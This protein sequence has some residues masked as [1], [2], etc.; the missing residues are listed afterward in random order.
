MVGGD[1]R[2]KRWDEWIKELEKEAEEKTK[3]VMR[4]AEKETKKK[5]Q[6]LGLLGVVD[7]VGIKNM[8]AYDG[9]EVCELVGSYMLNL[10]AK[11]CDKKEIGLYRDD[12]LGLSKNRSG[13]QN[14]SD[15]QSVNRYHS[16]VSKAG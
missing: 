2:L 5:E 11:R 1:P 13:P 16:S 6:R 9:A 12:G 8:G 4:A 14:E 7:T 10:I 15:V 3:E